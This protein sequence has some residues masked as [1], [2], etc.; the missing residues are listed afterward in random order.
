MNLKAFCLSQFKQ[1]KIQMKSYSLLSKFNHISGTTHE[2]IKA[3]VSVQYPELS[4]WHQIK[5]SLSSIFKKQRAAYLALTDSH[6]LHIQTIGEDVLKTK[7]YTL[8][9]L[10]DIKF[11][12]KNGAEQLKFSTVSFKVK[13]GKKHNDHSHNFT[14]FPSLFFSNLAYSKNL[15]EIEQ[16]SE[17]RQNLLSTLG[18]LQERTKKVSA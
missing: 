6:L 8:N 18:Q 15:A 13:E 12:V 11:G 5:I 7:K 3:I 4:T 2:P 9:D 1:K 17:M 14:I 16:M 10:H